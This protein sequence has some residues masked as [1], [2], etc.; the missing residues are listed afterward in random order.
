MD[1]MDTSPIGSWTDYLHYKPH[2]SYTPA[3]FQISRRESQLALYSPFYFPQTLYRLFIDHSHFSAILHII[4]HLDFPFAHVLP[5]AVLRCR[6]QSSIIYPRPRIV[7]A[8]YEHPLFLGTWFFPT[9]RH[10]QLRGDP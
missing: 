2:S 5:D 7:Q 9:C 10:A 6:A 3:P 4:L 1:G 8:A